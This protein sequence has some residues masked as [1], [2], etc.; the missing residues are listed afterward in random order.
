M[1]ITLDWKHIETG[2]IS[3]PRLEGWI[4]DYFGQTQDLSAFERRNEDIG[5]E[6]RNS[7]GNM[8][9]VFVGPLQLERDFKSGMERSKQWYVAGG[10]VI[11][12]EF[13]DNKDELAGFSWRAN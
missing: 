2:L 10:K 13:V 5:L 6:L 1:T 3:R 9:Y 8:G 4:K 12:Q 11:L 7:E